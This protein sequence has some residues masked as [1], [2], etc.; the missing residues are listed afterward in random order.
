LLL[1]LEEEE[2]RVVARELPQRDE[3]VAQVQPELVVLGVVDEEALD[4]LVDLVP[5]LLC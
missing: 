2:L 5:V 1:L 4:E 3:E